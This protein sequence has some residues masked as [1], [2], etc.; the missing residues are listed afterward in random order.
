MSWNLVSNLDSK[1]RSVPSS[2][3]R[4]G[5]RHMGAFGAIR[6]VHL[7]AI[8][9]QRQGSRSTGR[10]SSVHWG[11]FA[12]TI[13]YHFYCGTATTIITTGRSS[14]SRY[15]NNTSYP[16]DLATRCSGVSC[17]ITID[18]LGMLLVSYCS[19]AALSTGLAEIRHFV[20]LVCHATHIAL[21]L[22]GSG[23]IPRLHIQKVAPAPQTA[24]LH[25]SSTRLLS[26]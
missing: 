17:E 16:I 6:A 14:S 12:G 24:R 20:R 13:L 18:A 11:H 25:A 21:Q 7:G 10:Y 23:S 9:R 19:R 15:R 22:R 8:R 5:S 2:S 1:A 26:M 4:R 3:S